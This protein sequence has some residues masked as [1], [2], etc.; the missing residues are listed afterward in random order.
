MN[1]KKKKKTKNEKQY[2][3]ETKTMHIV[4]PSFGIFSVYPALGV[5]AVAQ[6]DRVQSAKQAVVRNAFGT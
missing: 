1:Q 4:N 6:R 3:N 5:S 2:E